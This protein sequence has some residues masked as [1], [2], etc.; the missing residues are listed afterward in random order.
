MEPHVGVTWWVVIAQ[1]KMEEETKFLI[2]LFFRAMIAKTMT[3][4]KHSFNLK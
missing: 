3:T 1:L 2:Y 4:F